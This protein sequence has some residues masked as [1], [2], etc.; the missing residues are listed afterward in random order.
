MAEVSDYWAH[1]RQRADSDD[2]R[3]DRF[4]RILAAAGLSP[5]TRSVSPRVAYAAGAMLEKV[6]GLFGLE[7][8]PIM[9]RFV[10]QQLSTEHWF[11]LTA[12]RRD[13]GYE[14]IV[15]IDEGMRRLADSLKEQGGG[16]A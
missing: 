9:T 13:L 3:L 7:S 14:P 2:P 8:E 5:V 1:Y 15:S 16:A 12:A 4:C 10:A 11:D 6:Y